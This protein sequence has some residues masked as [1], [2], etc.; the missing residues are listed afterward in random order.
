MFFVPTQ[1]FLI[2]RL[3][4]QTRSTLFSMP[5]IFLLLLAL[6]TTLLSACTK[7]YDIGFYTFEKISDYQAASKVPL[8][9]GLNYGWILKAPL[10][11]KIHWKEELILPSSSKKPASYSLPSNTLT[12]EKMEEAQP[13]GANPNRD[14]GLIGHFWTVAPDDPEGIYQYKIYIDE[15]LIKTF[16]IEFYK[17]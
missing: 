1:P 14:Y 6:C 7:D 8:R 2:H 15:K 11:Q 13:S 12:T 9:P 4:Q 16:E 17:E 10:K 5:S 3:K